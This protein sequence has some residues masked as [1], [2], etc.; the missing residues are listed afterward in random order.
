MSKFNSY[1]AV[2]SAS[3][4]SIASAIAG[5]SV[6]P[7]GSLSTGI[8]PK[9]I[10]AV[11]FDSDGFVDLAIANS[12]SS[13][14]T[15]HRSLGDGSF[16][17]PLLVNIPGQANSL[18]A[19]DL[20]S[21][22]DIDL[23]TSNENTNTTSIVMNVRTTSKLAFLVTQSI[24]VGLQPRHLAAAD[25][26][27]DGSIDLVVVNRAGGTLSLLKNGGRGK[28]ASSGALNVGVDA[29]FVAT[30]DIDGDGDLDLAVAR[31]D[32]NSLLLFKNEGQF[33]FSVPTTIS[34][35]QPTAVIG[36]DIDGDG[37][38]DLAITAANHTAH[39]VSILKNN[40]TGAFTPAGTFT[41]GADP[42]NLVAVDLD[43]DGDLDLATANTQANTMTV[44][45]NNGTGA[46]ASAANL[47]T[48]LGATGIATGDFDRDGDSDLAVTNVDSV[49]V[50][51][52]RNDATVGFQGY[53]VGC[54][55]A[56]GVVPT[57]SGLG[58]ASPGSNVKI[59]V[60]GGAPNALSLLFV[61]TA[62]AAVP[63]KGCTFLVGGSFFLGAGLDVR[64]D[65]VGSS[66]LITLI[67]EGAL[68][69]NVFTQ[70]IVFDVGAANGTFSA[71]NGLKISIS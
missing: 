8:D 4:F 50:S 69:A 14:L 32:L 11:D 65:A 44:L 30:T 47:P 52:F 27:L 5:I 18:I 15:I 33:K 1:L 23:A 46:F 60:R 53:G 42:Q 56:F 45:E 64:L 17:A 70:V 66:E 13:F 68:N 49:S 57:L 38:H 51:L 34:I 31:H 28:F 6:A 58:V 41:T 16:A 10:V 54:A 26:D 61:G 20:D 9:G 67:P 62:A 59:T 71:T 39:G 55:G 63:V 37:D 2:A 40:G 19:A 29:R 7:N 22:G 3:A 36:A 35:L 12:A 48:L 43:H 21:D 25:F 24:T